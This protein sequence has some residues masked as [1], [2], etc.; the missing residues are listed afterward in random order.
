MKK[1]LTEK[2]VYQPNSRVKVTV[3]NKPEFDDESGISRFGRKVTIAVECGYSNEK[4][5]FADDD[6]IAKFLENID[7][8]DPQQTLLDDD[9]LPE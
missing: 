5:T 4:L 9:E 3:T 1:Q 2:I 7:V 6:A 8:E